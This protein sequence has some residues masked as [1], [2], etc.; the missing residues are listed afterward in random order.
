[1]LSSGNTN[2]KL[3]ICCKIPKCNSFI[4][5]WHLSQISS[6]D[7]HNLISIHVVKCRTHI[8][9]QQLIKTNNGTSAS[10]LKNE[11]MFFL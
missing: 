8:K 7:S 1:M 6:S 3:L 11:D 4:Q 9:T 5:L 2:K 10:I